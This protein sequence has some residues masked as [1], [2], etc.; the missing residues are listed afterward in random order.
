MAALWQSLRNDRPKD[1]RTA[2]DRTRARDRANGSRGTS[3]RRRRPSLFVEERRTRWQLR[4]R[5]PLSVAVWMTAVAAS[6]PLIIGIL[7]TWGDANVTNPI[8][9]TIMGVGGWLAAPFHA[10]FTLSN[11]DHQT[12]LNWGI[13]AGTYLVAGRILAWVLRW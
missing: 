4:R 3:R 1:D 8:V 5:N 13:A 6:V 9:S 2:G 10:M 7:L 11:P 12:M